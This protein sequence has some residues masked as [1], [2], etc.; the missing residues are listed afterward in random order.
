MP[1]RTEVPERSRPVVRA[2]VNVAA[3]LVLATAAYLLVR[4]LLRLAPMTM[5]IIVALLLAALIGP[6]TERLRRWGAPATLAALAGVTGL[7]ALLAGV[8]YLIGRRATSELD[9]LRAQV[10]EGIDRLR[11]SALDTLPGLDARRLDEITAAAADAAR[12]ALPSPVAGATSA[13]EFL[14]SALL[15]IFLLFFFLRDGEQMWCWLVRLVGSPRADRVDRAGRSGWHTLIAYTHG[16]A[17]VAAVD[18]IG[19]GAALFILKVPLALSLAVLT[20]VS[21]FVPIIGATVAGAAAAL[22]T[23]VTNGPRDALIVIAAV[24]IVQQLEGNLLQPLV[25]RRAI[26]LHPV[27][28]LLAVTAG[29]LAAG[30]AGALI[31]VP[32]CAVAY[33]TTLGYRNED[34]EEEQQQ[35]DASTPDP[36]DEPAPVGG[37]PA[38]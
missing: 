2:A 15:A 29:T 37:S 28:T 12:R 11:Q 26:R 23:L 13:A 14:A 7:L 9:D 1:P 35:D 8:S 6:L 33:H 5:A 38:G 25:M 19:I 30:V 3:V 27:V 32:M 18:A 17:A 20:F 24:V 10:V 22:V 31:A 21:A 36:D 34:P 16:T 4:V